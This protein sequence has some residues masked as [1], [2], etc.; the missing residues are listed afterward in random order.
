MS[1]IKTL[2]IQKALENNWEEAAR[3]NEELLTQN[4]SDIETLN[5]LGFAYMKLGKLKK[6]KEMYKLV[7][8]LDKTN[9]IASKNIRKINSISVDDYATVAQRTNPSVRLDEIFIEEAGKTKI[10]ELKNIADKATLSILQAG[11][12]I[13][14]VIKRSKIFAQTESKK[15]VGMIPDNIGMRLIP[16][17][18][19]GNTYL[20]FI[21]SVDEKTVVVF[22]KE[23][24]RAKRFKNQPSFTTFGVANQSIADLDLDK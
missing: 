19:G 24:T 5:R 9:P 23:T 17:I 10:V 20:G 14:L 12:I 3:L 2:A 6:A 8:T 13:H 22:V 11:D 21:K 18:Q 16:F 7:L 4:S 1:L 15:Y